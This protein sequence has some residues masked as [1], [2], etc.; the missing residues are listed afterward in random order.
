MENTKLLTHSYYDLYLHQYDKFDDEI[1]VTE[2]MRQPD[3]E[4]FHPIY[5]LL[6]RELR[7]PD[8]DEIF[9]LT[10][11]EA[12]QMVFGISN[13]NV[14]TY[15]SLADY[16]YS[17][18]IL[19]VRIPWLMLNFRDPSMKEIEDDFW[20]NEY[21]SGTYIEDI[22][23][24]YLPKESESAQMQPYRWENWDYYPYFERLRN[25][26]YMLQKEF[27]TLDVK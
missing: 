3:S 27:A 14:D 1:D 5:M 15:N 26:Y 7:L 25:S 10:K 21:Y 13:Y 4:L 12:G 16:Y 22:W 19:E 18:D 17:G 6:E 9:P 20:L 2:A 23:I 24:G 11:F 8:R